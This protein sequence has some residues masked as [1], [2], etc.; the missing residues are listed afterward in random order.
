MNSSFTTYANNLR[1][2]ASVQ[3]CPIASPAH[4]LGDL[5]ARTRTLTWALRTIHNYRVSDPTWRWSCR[6]SRSSREVA[7]SG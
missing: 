3:S 5:P 2:H 4:D 6:L 7:G 1:Y